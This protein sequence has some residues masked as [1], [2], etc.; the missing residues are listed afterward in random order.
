MDSQVQGVIA[1]VRAALTGKGQPLPVDFDLE[2][3][4]DAILQHNIAVMALE[5]AVLCGLDKK[6]PAMQKLFVRAF[7][8]IGRVEAQDRA[9]ERLF[10]A[11]EEAGIEFMP[12]KGA[13]LR[14]LY[15]RRDYRSMGDMD[16]LIRLEQ[17]E[18]IKEI[19]AGLNF[20]ERY[21]SE[22]ELIWDH[23]DL[24][25]E[26]HKHLIESSNDTY[27]A[28]YGSGWDFARKSDTSRYTMRDEDAFV[29]VFTHFA[30]HYRDGGVGIRQVCDLYLMRRSCPDMDEEYIC[31]E[32][33][34]LD[35]LVFYRNI[36]Q[37]LDAWFAGEQ[38]SEQT[39]FISEIIYAS[40]TFGQHSERILAYGA[41]MAGDKKASGLL[42]YKNALW[43]V[44]LPL[45]EMQAHY[46]LLNKVPV[47]LPV[48]WVYRIVHTLFFERHKIR[49][50]QQAFSA[51]KKEN[52]QAYQ[53]ALHYV[54]LK[55]D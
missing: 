55:Y 35:L 11:F 46:P 27:H 38:P 44:F 47:L 15:P 2:K 36:L 7:R 42:R 48:M 6:L 18:K 17:Y 40:G 45:K 14:D 41:R 54:G 22:Y 21:E 53:R 32:L 24:H 8:D 34:K 9:S 3:V 19:L 31:T 30:R 4:Y 13:L 29:Y 28:Y 39:D 51:Y 37:M 20:E 5:G 26:L 52:V 23:R 43:H 1:L 50:N 12:V 10:A 16:V 49:R 33:G 25:L